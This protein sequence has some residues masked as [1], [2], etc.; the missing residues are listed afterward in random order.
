MSKERIYIVE[1]ERIIAIDLQR[2]LE[3]LGYTVCGIAS[4]GEAALAGI[5]Q[6]IPAL[7]LMDIVLQ[8]GIDGIDVAITIKDE[9]HIPV[10]FLSA[11]TDDATIERAKKANPLGYILKPF[12]ERELATM[13]EMALFKSVA[14]NQIREKEQ[15]FS[16]ILNSTTDAILVTSGENSEIKFLNPEAEQI[17]EISDAEAKSLRINDLFTLSDMDSGDV[18]R[19]PRLSGELKVLKARNLRLTNRRQHSYIVELTINKGLIGNKDDEE[20]YILS[21]KDISRL[22]EMT[23]TLK[24]QTSHD[25]LT[26]LLNRNELAMRMNAT[27]SRYLAQP[28]PVCALFIDIDHFRIINDSCGTQAG[29]QLLIE[30]ANRIRGCLSGSDYAARFGGDDFVLV[31]FGNQEMEQ[32]SNANAIAR[33]LIARTQGTPF[34]WEGKEYPITLSIGIVPFDRS[35]K[36]EHDIMI[37]GNQTVT[38][39]H[40]SGGNR[41]SVYSGGITS[42]S[43]AIPISEWISKI[44]EALLHDRFKLYYQPILPLDPQ[45]THAKL[46]VLLRMVDRDGSIIMP[47]EFIPIAERYNIMPTIDRWVIKK[48]FEIFAYMQGEKNPLADSIFCVNLSGASLADESII[49]FIIDAVD[50][51]RVPPDRFCIEVTESNAILNLTSASR[52]IH[53]LKEQGFTIALDDFGSG[54]SS[55]S[56]LKNLPVDYLKIDGCFIRNMDKDK[57]DYTMVQ[58]ISSMCG[59][60]GLKTI[61]E[62]AENETIIAQLREIGV[63]YAQG[64]GIS[65]PKP[66]E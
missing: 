61:G 58:A 7:V 48:T 22:H 9:L 4:S 55:F 19:I 49:G 18:F 56:Y 53:L 36:T 43:V 31:Y 65:R 54:F 12:K 14:D 50:E 13:L 30:T 23:D 64:Y 15:L 8:G 66:L 51:Y 47:S 42:G 40:L 2:R 59:V 34:R 10:I 60:L 3:R 46:E 11:Y 29:D 63:T 24:Y 25:T 28:I 16:A 21:F 52:F 37:A 20:S 26:G 32:A 62:F 1:D 38:S 6:N 27:L 39:T 35:F 17:L 57:V 44:H 33:E 5:R 45:N 41:Y